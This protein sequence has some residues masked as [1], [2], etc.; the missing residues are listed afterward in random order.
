MGT[1]DIYLRHYCHS[2]NEPLKN[3][4]QLSEKDVL[5]RAIKNRNENPC[6]AHSRFGPNTGSEIYNKNSLNINCIS[7]LYALASIILAFAVVFGS[8][9]SFSVNNK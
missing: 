8:F 6:H 9:F 1:K 7:F 2:D 3:I 4:T 5:V